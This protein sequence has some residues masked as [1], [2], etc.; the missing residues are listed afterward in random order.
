[1]TVALLWAAALV[2]GLIAYNVPPSP[3]LFNQAAAL[4]LW[5]AAMAA[6]APA[7][8]GGARAAASRSAPLHIALL[9]L[10]IAALLSSAPGALPWAIGLS[11]AGLI[12]TA[13]A[14]A[15]GASALRPTPALLRTYP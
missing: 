3:T 5:G 4:A 7:C 12:F 13:M 8:V 1:M 9:L 11:S 2:P 6:L 15:L 10:A 14:V